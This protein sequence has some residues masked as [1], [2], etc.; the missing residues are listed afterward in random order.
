M[1]FCDHCRTTL[2]FPTV[3]ARDDWEA[4]HQHVEES[5]HG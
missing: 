3:E 4:N 2:I 1:G 5:D